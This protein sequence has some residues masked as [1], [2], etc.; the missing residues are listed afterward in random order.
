MIGHWPAEDAP[1]WS[2]AGADDASCNQVSHW[3]DSV[4]EDWTF[5]AGPEPT[6]GKRVRIINTEA[7]SE[8]RLRI[9]ARDEYEAYY[10]LEWGLGN[11]PDVASGERVVARA[12]NLAALPADAG[13]IRLVWEL[14]A[15][16]GADVRVSANHGPSQ[17][18]PIQGHLT[19]PGR[20]LLLPAYPPGTHL[21]I[22]ILPV[23]A[24]TPIG[25]EGD[26]LELTV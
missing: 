22:S 5:L 7:T 26:T 23:A 18:V 19:V 10:P 8:R 25:I 4:P 15:A 16:N 3:P 2:D 6:P 11:V 1:G 9:V 12:F 13:G 24:G 21:T 17:Q 14:E 20:E